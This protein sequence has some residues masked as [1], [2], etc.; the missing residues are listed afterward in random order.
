MPRDSG[1]RGSSTCTL[2]CRGCMRASAR[3]LS[4]AAAAKTGGVLHVT[5]SAPPGLF[6]PQ[7]L[8]AIEVVCSLCSC[9]KCSEVH[10]YEELATLRPRI[11]TDRSQIAV[12]SDSDR[13]LRGV[14]IWVYTSGIHVWDTTE[15]T[16]VVL[17]TS[18]TRVYPRV[19]SDRPGEPLA[20]RQWAAP[21]AAARKPL[22]ALLRSC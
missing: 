15:E 6:Y 20:P 13:I 21:S 18:S 5:C 10:S 8:W 19:T 2:P 7:S 12:G 16:G 1:V 9:P 3:R 22:P 17:S 4:T 11:S 14:H